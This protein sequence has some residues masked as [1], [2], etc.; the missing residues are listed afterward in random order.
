MGSNIY[1]EH[2]RTHQPLYYYTL[3][4][5]SPTLLSYYTLLLC[6][7]TILIAAP[8]PVQPENHVD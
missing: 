3:L 2:H 4:L 8:D 1:F 7:P 5:Y 6:S